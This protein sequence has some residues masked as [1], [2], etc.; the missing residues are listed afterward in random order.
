MS[1][2][3]RWSGRFA[4]RWWCGDFTLEDAME[5]LLIRHGRKACDPYLCP[6]P[7]VK[8]CLS[9]DA[10][11]PQARDLAAALRSARAPLTANPHGWPV[12]GATP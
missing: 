8:G 7:P 5:L 2:P 10:G 1:T 3:Q 11:L 12:A 9:E 6:A 4:G